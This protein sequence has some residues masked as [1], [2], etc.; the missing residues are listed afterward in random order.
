[1]KKKV[2]TIRE[3]LGVDSIESTNRSTLYNDFKKGGGHV[4]NLGDDY[5]TAEK[6]KLHRYFEEKKSAQEKA[7]AQEERERQREEEAKLDRIL[8]NKERERKAELEKNKQT[9]IEKNKKSHEQPEINQTKHQKKRKG[10]AKLIELFLSKLSCIFSGVFTL[11]GGRFSRRF[12]LKNTLITLKSKLL[13][14]SH[15]LISVLHQDKGVIDL[16]KSILEKEDRTYYFELLAR[17]DQILDEK[18]F[19]FIAGTSLEV[20]PIDRSEPYFKKLFK[21][22]YIIIPYFKLLGNAVEV[23][24]KIEQ[25]TRSLQI[26]TVDNNIRT[27][28]NTIDYVLNKYYPN[29]EVLINYYF[30]RYQNTYK[31]ADMEQFLELEKKDVIGYYTHI[32]KE[33]KKL[34]Q[35][36][37][38]AAKEE[39]KK[40]EI[41]EYSEDILENIYEIPNLSDSTRAGL[42]QIYDNLD[43]EKVIGFYKES[44]DARKYFKL[45]DKVFLTYSLID[46][47]EKEFSFLFISDIVQYNVFSDD[48]GRKIEAKKT[49]KYI[50]YKFNGIYRKIK[51]YLKLLVDYSRV[52]SNVK[53]SHGLIRHIDN[54]RNTL[55]VAISSETEKIVGDLLKMFQYIVKDGS[56]KTK[57]IVNPNDILEFGKN[58]KYNIC[59]NISIMEAFILGTEFL[60][61][62]RFLLLHGDLTTDTLFLEKHI[63]LNI[64][65]PSDDDET[66]D[67][68]TNTNKI[69][70]NKINDSE[71]NKYESINDEIKPPTNYNNSDFDDNELIRKN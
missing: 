39:E 28:L 27:V 54:Q 71:I 19:Q 10:F 41:S 22:I 26:M 60:S 25:Q 31:N 70:G 67:S 38:E 30:Q 15:I 5:E 61:A 16:I 47:F 36:K 52:D 42:K 20:N 23:I 4:V 43:F 33:E 64:K 1:M 7:L 17:F 65:V 37:A 34:K 46:F 18:N 11:F 9:S 6:N 58:I 3:K 49:I 53:E 57:V 45:T 44:Q 35:K 55:L 13:D 21:N 14:T 40:Q 56:D 29:I 50:H 68:E 62:F 2:E 69:S 51:E 63:F 12:L 24:L 66:D 59:S 32:W 8:W 48:L